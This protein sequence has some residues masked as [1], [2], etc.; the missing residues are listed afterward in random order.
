MAAHM[1]RLIQQAGASYADAVLAASLLGPAQVAAGFAECA[2]ARNFHPLTT[3]RIAALGHP[4]GAAMLAAF[5]AVLS[6]PFSLLHG[7]GNGI[8]TIAR[9]T[10]PLAVFGPDNYGYRIGLLGAPARIAQA[11]APLLFGLLIDTY[12]LATIVLTSALS[13]AALVS[14]M[15]V[16]TLPPP[17]QTNAG[18]PT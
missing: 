1:P 11:F 16:P 6:I 18:D 5:G 15:L 8:L 10:V 7:A 14:L 3:A 12:G 13:L 17:A 2:L 9:G 4:L